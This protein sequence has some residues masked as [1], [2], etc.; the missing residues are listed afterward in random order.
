MQ[1]LGAGLKYIDVGGGLGVDYDGSKTNFGSIDQLRPPGIRQRRG[2]PHQGNL[3]RGRRRASDDHQRIRPGDGRLPQRAGLQ[4]A[5]LE[6]L[7]PL[8][9]ARPT[10]TAEQ[11]EELPA[12]VVN[13]FDTYQRHR[14]STTTRS[15]TT[16][17]RS[18]RT[19]CCNLFNLGYCSLEH[20]SLAERL[21]FGICAKVLRHHPQDGIRA[22]GVRRA[23]KRCSPTPI[24]ATSRSSSRCPT[25]WA[26][27]QL[28][29]I[30]PIHRLDEEPDLP[31]HPGRHHLRLRRQG[32]SLHRPPRREERAGTA[33]L[34]RRG[35]LPGRVPRRRV[36]GNP[37]RPAQSPRR[38]QRRARQRRRRRP[39]HHR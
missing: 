34:Q 2:L 23:S 36:P 22:R 26:I 20:R 39:R 8:R 27:D 11:R 3:R 33:R 13:L 29:P 35:L 12:P 6:R 38:H 31:R 5:G 17:P 25:S 9:S 19:P 21:F 32:R 1:R 16:T 14:T 10:L 28:F 18:P 4:R 7:R 37:R 15:I 24:S 30:M